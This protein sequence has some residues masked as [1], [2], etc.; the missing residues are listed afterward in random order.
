MVEHLQYWH[1]DI[2]GQYKH[3]EKFWKKV[4]TRKKVN[5]QLRGVVPLKS[6]RKSSAESNPQGIDFQGL[7]RLMEESKKLANGHRDANRDGAGGSAAVDTENRINGATSSSRMKAEPFSE[8]EQERKAHDV[9]EHR[10]KRDKNLAGPSPANNAI[11]SK[12]GSWSQSGMFGDKELIDLFEGYRRIAGII[13]LKEY[14]K[15]FEC[16]II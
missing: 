10:E 11:C 15:M 5:P 4:D 9:Q 7:K 14:T 6:P 16:Q 12:T 13:D 1:Q 3:L 2:Y 8:V